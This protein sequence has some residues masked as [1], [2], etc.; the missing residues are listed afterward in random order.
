MIALPQIMVAPTGARR[1]RADHPQLP[2]APQQIAATARACQLAGAGAIHAHVR[3][4][5]GGHLLDASRYQQVVD[6]VAE[7]AP[8]MLVQ[9]S[10]EAVGL[11][12][13]PAQIQLVRD[14]R[15]KAISIA[16]REIA[17]TRAE[18]SSAAAFYAWCD[19]ADIA[20][21]HILYDAADLERLAGMVTSGAVD[22]AKLSL[23]YV[24]GR[25]TAGQQSH[26]SE[27]APFH[28]AAADLPQAPDWMVCAF[29]LGETDCLAA[30]LQAGGKVR[31]G[32]ENNLLHADG[33]VADSNQS[34]V[35]AIR[36]IADTLAS[37]PSQSVG[38][39]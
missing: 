35:A 3:D 6:L 5:D 26:P 1:T 27:L 17:P 38:Q 29:G 15:P 13:P 8:G 2:I 23:L 14:L 32:F 18:E 4:D 11:Y 10:T 22:G 28:A 20:V 34:R 25:Y 12:R 21:Q 36:Q 24:L 9:I 30:A 19:S 16:L 37:I 7:Q 33:R 31:V 39:S